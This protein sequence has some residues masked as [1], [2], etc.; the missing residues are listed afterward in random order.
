MHGKMPNQSS[1]V[2]GV[3]LGFTIPNNY[4]SEHVQDVAHTNNTSAQSQMVYLLI[5]VLFITNGKLQKMV[6]FKR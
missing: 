6:S 1:C 5:R 2:A 3:S 4:G